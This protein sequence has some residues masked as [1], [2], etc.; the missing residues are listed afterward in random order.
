MWVEPGF[1]LTTH[2]LSETRMP[3][4]TYDVSMLLISAKCPVCSSTATCPHP[5]LEVVQAVFLH[6]SLQYN[7]HLL[8]LWDS[9]QSLLMLVCIMVKLLKKKN[10]TDLL[11]HVVCQIGLECHT[12]P[13]TVM[14][15][16]SK[17]LLRVEVADK[18]GLLGKRSLLGV[19]I[20]SQKTR[21]Y[22]SVPLGP[23]HSSQLTP[24]DPPGC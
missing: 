7:P 24:G 5:L 9:T 1:N 6:A 23:L 8:I 19:L 11:A 18:G 22:P 20:Q 10:L 13:T 3:A 15:W 21:F 17:Y 4:P 16:A 2:K 14:G 12:S